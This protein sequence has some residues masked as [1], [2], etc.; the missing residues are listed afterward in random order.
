VACLDS[1]NETSPGFTDVSP[2]NEFN[3]QWFWMTC[4][5]PFFYWQ[6]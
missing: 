2:D 3:R 5:E 4:N 6:V 1:Y